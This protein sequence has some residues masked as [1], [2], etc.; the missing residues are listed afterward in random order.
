MDSRET[1]PPP[2]GYAFGPFVVDTTR[3]TVWRDGTHVPLNGKSL[4]VLLLLLA[5]RERV[6]TKDE[7]LRQ[8]WPDTFVQENNLARHIS[9][10]RK[11]LG[12]RPDEH[13][14]ILTV[15][16]RGYRFVAPVETLDELPTELTSGAADQTAPPPASPIVVPPAPGANR[17]VSR[18]ALAVGVG[19]LAVVAASVLFAFRSDLARTLAPS[20]RVLHQMTYGPSTQITPAWAPDGQAF[21]YASDVQGT[22]DLFVQHADGSEAVRL[23]SSPGQEWQPAWSPDGKWIAFRSE[24]DG[25]GLFVMPSAGGSARRISTFGFAPRWSSDSTRLLFVN[26]Q[27]DRPR[28]RAFIVGLDGQAPR[29][30]RADL[31]QRLYSPTF[32]WHPD[33]HRISV[34]G[35]TRDGQWTFLTASVDGDDAVASAIPASVRTMT[36][37]LS[38]RL[39]QFVWAASGRQILFEGRSHEAAN[40]WR[41]D[42]DPATLAWRGEL[43]R[44]TTGPG[45]D[46]SLS[47]STDGH[48]LAFETVTERTRIWSLP[49]SPLTGKVEGTGRPVTPGAAGE[50]DVAVSQDEQRLVY[51]TTMD[52]RQELWQVSLADGHSRRLLSDPA[53]VRSAPRWSPDG[54]SLTYLISAR[55]S[56]ANGPARPP[57]LAIISTSGG[58]ERILAA[59]ITSELIPDDWS[60]DG[61]SILG[62]CRLQDTGRY[63]VCLVPTSSTGA[64][65]LLVSDPDRSLR[66][67]RFSPNQQWITF[68]A[69]AGNSST[70]TVYVRRTV[71]GPMVAMTDG[72]AFEDKAHW[73]PDGRTLYFVSN[74]GGFLNI[75]GRRFD[76]ATGQPVGDVFQATAFDGIRRGL[77]TD[78]SVVDVAVT[79][80]Q[81][82]IP[83][84][85]RS[86]QIWALQDV[87]P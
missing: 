14:Y 75:S 1:L 39:G 46:R 20:P 83:I 81:L 80:T 16:G 29:P 68:T 59:S 4:E 66:N 71:G 52:G 58:P 56:G 79:N 32:G 44:L 47:L 69:N 23:T 27:V 42:V 10:V 37:S 74:R 40:I 84:T 85:E 33:G 67:A 77:A 38:L 34:A 45:A 51:R 60:A 12:Q 26:S 5:C 50:F 82:F 31:A 65:Q 35:T 41:V 18:A 9:T 57:A 62:A 76:S 24:A 64:P 19:T 43:E 7:M 25:G 61:K 17:L 28:P 3:Q 70:S 36:Q 86:G 78:L 87:V 73:S 48:R 2:A 63:G 22:F 53:G 8:I 15:Q 72:N 49:I 13:D 54:A 30:C 21:A 11:A 6:V 55:P